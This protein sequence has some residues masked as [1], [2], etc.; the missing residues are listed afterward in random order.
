MSVFNKVAVITIWYD[1]SNNEF[2]ETFNE[3]EDNGKDLAEDTM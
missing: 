1:D 3:E 2:E